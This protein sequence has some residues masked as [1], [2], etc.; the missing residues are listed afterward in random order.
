MAMYL[1]NIMQPVG[2]PPSAVD[3]SKIMAD[4]GAVI[5]ET[6]TTGAWVFN[7]GLTQPS[8]STVVTITDGKPLFTDGPY[9]EGKE[10]IGGFIIVRAADLDGALDWGAKL[11]R[12][13]TLPIEVRPFA[14]AGE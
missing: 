7:G 6:K 11:S 8:A 9:L 14:H 1:L 3:L 2:Q 10:F 13:I 12:A 4:V 5:A